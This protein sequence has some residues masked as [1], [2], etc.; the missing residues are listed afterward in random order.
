MRQMA[1]M[2][3]D[4]VLA[5]AELADHVEIDRQKT[6]RRVDNALGAPGGA[7]GVAD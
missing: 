4:V 2:Y 6:F 1:D 5:E 3:R 7:T